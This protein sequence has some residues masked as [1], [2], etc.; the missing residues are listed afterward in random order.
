MNKKSTIAILLAAIL[1]TGIAGCSSA[2][3]E[4]EPGLAF[5]LSLELN[6]QTRLW[7]ASHF[8][9][10][11]L[12]KA[13]PEHGIEEGEIRVEFYDSGKIGTERQLL[14]ANYFG[15]VEVIQINSSVLTTVAPAFSILD[16]PFVFYNNDHLKATL[17]GDIGRQMM[18]RL[19]PHGLYGLSFYSGG[20]RN[21]FYRRQGEQCAET[22]EDL[23]G[24]RL[25]VMESPVMISAMNA[26]G[27]RAT[28]IPHSEVYQSIRTG[29]IDGAENS[30]AIVAS[31]R[32]HET[33]VN[34]LTISE[35]FTNQHIM[36]ANKKWLDSLEPKYRDRILQVAEEIVP[37][38][39]QAWD[40][41]MD[42]AYLTLE[43]QG[44]TV[45]EVPD[46]QPF[47]D[48]TSAIAESFLSNNPNVPRELYQQIQALGEQHR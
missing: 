28:P 44:I 45:N 6:Q 3:S 1:W 18:D 30:P 21:M 24:L 47:F 32:Y 34:C 46:K 12:M 40:T 22:P 2:D 19:E 14:E 16:L 7:D 10:T 15:V 41:S 37:A 36:V 25:R 43:Q 11:E 8:F 35:H 38:F 13:S 31:Y 17:Y 4:K 27:P 23:E 39:N 26:M 29:V 33:G 9:R 48:R 42:E 5:R 20:F